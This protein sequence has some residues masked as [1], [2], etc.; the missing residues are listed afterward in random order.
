MVYLFN[1]HAASALHNLIDWIILNEDDEF[2]TLSLYMQ[3]FE[4]NLKVVPLPS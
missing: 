2:K 3:I 1:G 4:N